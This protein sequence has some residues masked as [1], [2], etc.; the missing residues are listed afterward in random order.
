MSKDGQIFSIYLP[1]LKDVVVSDSVR[2]Q[3]EKLLSKGYQDLSLT[4]KHSKITH[5][6]NHIFLS[7]LLVSRK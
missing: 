2:G 5:Q 1:I 3:I 6:D 7:N 4:P